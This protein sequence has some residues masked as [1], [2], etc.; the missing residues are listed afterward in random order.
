MLAVA[1]GLDV[2]VIAWYWP[3]KIND[4]TVY[5]NATCHTCERD[6]PSMHQLGVGAG[7]ATA[8]SYE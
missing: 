4:I 1:V 6:T 2:L 5:A 3:V 8:L 7:Q